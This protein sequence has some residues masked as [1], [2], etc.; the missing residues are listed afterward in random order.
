MKKAFVVS[1]LEHLIRPKLSQLL[2][3]EQFVKIYS[4][5]RTWFLD[6]LASC[7]P[8][9]DVP[10]AEVE[11]HDLKF[12]NC[13][14]NAAGFDKDGKLLAFNYLMGAG[15]AVV[16]TVLSEPRSGNLI[17]AYGKKSN[18]WTPLPYS[19][20][21]INSLGLPNHG[22]QYVKRNIRKFRD[23]FSPKDFPI[24]ASVMGHPNHKDEH[25]KLV[26][27]MQCVQELIPVVDG[28]EINESCPNTQH[29]DQGLELRLKTI[30][31]IRDS[32]EAHYGRYLPVWVKMRDAGNAYFTVEFMTKIGV[33]G[34][35]LTNTQINYT[36]L[37]KSVHEKDLSLFDHYTSTHKGGVSGPIIREFAL[38][39]VASAA[40][41]IDEQNSP[42][43]ITDIGGISNH[44]DIVRGKAINPAIVKLHEWY[45]GKMNAIGSEDPSS[46]YRNMIYGKN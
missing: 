17:P 21:A 11:V 29:S 7:R 19:K 33:D 12:R 23:N 36:E 20:S 46:I 40:R 3:P 42:L 38:S 34:L 31:G 6:M 4:R 8:E 41:A 25:Q 22:V 26:G 9:A 30:L 32:H 39:Q 37:R 15:G 1:S 16:G 28:F 45:T 24:I 10:R 43:V 18:P 5:T 14:M 2:P 44:R 27:I 35:A 13:L